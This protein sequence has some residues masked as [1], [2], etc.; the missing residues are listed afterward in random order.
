MDEDLRR[1]SPALVPALTDHVKADDKIA[2]QV[3]V[4]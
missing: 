4:D 3:R 2:A 1:V